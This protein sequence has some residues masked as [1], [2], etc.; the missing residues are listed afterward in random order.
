[1]RGRAAMDEARIIERLREEAAL[2]STFRKGSALADEPGMVE[3]EMLASGSIASTISLTG[4]VE[5]SY[6]SSYRTTVQ[7]DTDTGEILDF[8]CTCP[9][10]DNYPGLCKHEIALVLHWLDLQ[11]ANEARTA[12]GR[13]AGNI[14]EA[15]PR[16]PRRATRQTPLP[17]PTSPQI[18]ELLERLTMRRLQQVDTVRAEHVEPNASA[19][20]PAELLVGVTTAHDAH[21][22]RDGVWCVKLR[23]RRGAAT[24]VVKN[25]AALLDAYR[26][27]EVIRYGKN[28]AFAHV[29]EAFSE[30]ARRIIAVL[31]RIAASQQAL[32]L[33]R[34]RYQEAGRGT[35]IKELPV[36]SADLIDL[37]DILQGSSFTFEPDDGPYGSRGQARPIEVVPGDPPLSARLARTAGDGCDLA[38]EGASYAFSDGERLYLV[39]DQHAWRCSE[40]LAAQADLIIPLLRSTRFHIASANLPAFCRDILPALRRTVDVSAPAGIDDLVPPEAV[41]TFTIG[42]DDSRVSCQAAVAYGTWETELYGEAYLAAQRARFSPA[43]RAPEPVRD[44]VAEYRSMDVVE[45]LFPGGDIEAGE[46]PGFDEDDDEQLYDLLT[47]GLP[48]LDALGEVLLSERLRSI[49][50]RPNPRLE[51]HAK[52]S[53]GLLDVAVDTSGL[54][55]RDLAAYLD[56]LKRRQRFVRLS[57]GDIMRLGSEAEAVIDLADSLGVDAGAL[58]GGVEGLPPNRVLFVDG[59]VKRMGRESGLRLTRNDAFRAIVRDF[60]AYADAD[61]A[62]PDGLNA[63]LR[64]YQ[65]DGFRWLTLLDRFGFGGILADDMGL[66][67]TLQVIACL[68][69]AKERAARI[70]AGGSDSATGSAGAIGGDAE[71]GT[72]DATGN[73]VEDEDSRPQ[74]PT[75]V[76]CPASLVYNWLS[77]LERFAPALDAVAVL[78]TKTARARLITAAG[79]HDVLITSYDL[80]KRDI[81][82]YERQRFDRVVLDEAHYIKNPTTNVARAAKRL[83]ARMRLALTGTPIENRT[84]EL[85]SIFDF[86]M[87]GILGTRESFAKTYEGPIEA[88]EE[89]A[90]ARL[91]C[92]IA[93]FILRRRKAD[94]LADLPEKTESI[95]RTR[96][97]GEQAKLY[98]TNQDRIA[99]QVTHQLPDE[100][101]KKKLKILAELTKL[102]QIC[103]DP[104]L[105]F[106]G[107]RGGSAKLD[108]CMELVGS[109]LDGG[110]RILLFSQFTTMLDIISRRLRAEGVAHLVLT[111]DTGKAERRRLVER[112]QA[113]EVPVFLISLRAG[114]VG[115]NLTAADVVIHYD[116]WWN[117]AAQNQATDRAHRIGQERGV[118]VYKLVCSD[119]IEERILAMQESK[120]AL[121]EGL[122]SGDAV[123]S[124]KLTRDDVL[125][126]LKGTVG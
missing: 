2:S 39:D 88:G 1:M 90:T 116:P 50:V 3:I 81:E 61:V 60:D 67:K 14:A 38:L 37:L 111:G 63:E 72:E 119:T 40:E 45:R 18:A 100:F 87:P 24:Y 46:L 121:A 117:L 109:A 70:G 114:G 9:A 107:Y 79:K 51:V 86:L 27:G 108:A 65:V 53:H 113:G 80:M 76:V 59:L 34:W 36:A 62:V 115:L 5:G 43:T 7:F 105:A 57:S 85:W 66:G 64:P 124:T 83:P 101:K 54:S 91:R 52:V 29:P 94:V 26:T 68:L 98:Q 71:A 55:S 28:L 99:L 126:L 89:H 35:D 56:S 33:S 48:E 118:T 104:A 15:H 92:L 6:G 20:T 69:A 110:H 122:L 41:F 77:E 112:F 44:L 75:L 11:A 123:S 96:M 32:F 17:Q 16:Q 102:R 82:A 95:V 42:L 23:V 58:A 21:Y 49:R 30:Q 47:T 73:G 31:R 120:R 106:E 84:S 97:T 25:I 78:G 13:R 93:P 103:C 19:A 4:N 125:A 74:L 22:A 8:S 10:A 12:G